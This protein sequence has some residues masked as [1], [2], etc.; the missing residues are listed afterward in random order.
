MDYEFGSESDGTRSEKTSL[1][2]YAMTQSNA[3]PDESIMVGDRHYDIVSAKNN[4]L[5]Y[6]GVAYGYGV[7]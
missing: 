5:L 2:N 1:I 6:V 7:H 4:G 3:T